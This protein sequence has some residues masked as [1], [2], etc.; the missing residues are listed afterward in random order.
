MSY[1]ESTSLFFLKVVSENKDEL[2]SVRC[3]IKRRHKTQMILL[4]DLKYLSSSRK[5]R[6][7]C[8]A[9]REEAGF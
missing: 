7:L 6:H 8:I 3:G 2:C 5:I 4:S 1:D 9:L